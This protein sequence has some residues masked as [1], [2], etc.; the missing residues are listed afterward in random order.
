MNVHLSPQVVLVIF[1][2]VAINYLWSYIK[3][4]NTN[5]CVFVLNV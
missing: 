4:G 1:V 2:Y 5:M 3:S